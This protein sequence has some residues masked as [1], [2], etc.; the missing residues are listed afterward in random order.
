MNAHKTSEPIDRRHDATIRS[1]GLAHH[2]FGLLPVSMARTKP[3]HRS[4][5]TGP[6]ATPQ[7]RLDA[8][9][10]APLLGGVGLM[11]G[12]GAPNKEAAALMSVSQGENAVPGGRRRAG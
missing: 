12:I 3:C 2:H 5:R 4:I 6:Q 11:G 7:E 10:E 8:L 1:S 9:C